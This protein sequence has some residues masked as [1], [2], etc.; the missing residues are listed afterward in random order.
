MRITLLLVISV[1]FFLNDVT[2][3]SVNSNLRQG[4]KNYQDGDFQE[5]E[6]NFRKALERDPHD[7]RALY[8]LSNVLYRQGRYDEASNILEGLANMNLSDSK[9]ADILHNLGNS[10][11]GE[12]KVKDGIEAY[13]D[14]L[15]IRPQDMDTRH[16]LAYAMKLLQEQEQQQQ[17]NQD[18]QDDQQD[19]DQQDQ[20][21][22]DQDQQEQEQEEQQPRPD[23]ISP[24]DAERILD[25]LNQQEQKVQENIDREERQKVPVRVQREW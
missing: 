25:A 18:D 8:N 1:I 10:R 21:A 11:L 2:S 6:L 22:Q 14:A 3:Q 24:Q 5:A 7:I 4:N 15:R 13:K 9:R 16:N 17:Q 20:Q 12:Q 23:Q 19:Q